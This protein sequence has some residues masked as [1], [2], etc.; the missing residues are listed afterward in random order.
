M[1]IT[2]LPALAVGCRPLM[3]TGCA[4][5]CPRKVSSYA[6]RGNLNCQAM[7]LTAYTLWTR[8]VWTRHLDERREAVTHKASAELTSIPT[9]LPSSSSSSPP[10]PPPQQQQQQQS[11]HNHNQQASRPGKKPIPIRVS[12]I[13][14]PVPV[15]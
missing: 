1:N 5:A 7:G 2:A 9:S 6:E 13:S 8:R 3:P 14:L 4:H 12:D 10:S 15:S 11:S